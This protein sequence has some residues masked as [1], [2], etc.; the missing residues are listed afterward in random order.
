MLY[1]SGPGRW[2]SNGD[3]SCVRNCKAPRWAYFLSGLG[4]F[5]YQTLDAI[6]GKQA[7]RTKSSTPLG[8]LF[9]HGCDSISTG[10]LKIYFSAELYCGRLP[11][12]A[13]LVEVPDLPASFS[14]SIVL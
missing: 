9:D 1:I 3:W 7:R 11:S 4:L 12:A 13:L 10:G 5:I 14:P 8:E 2:F 6:D